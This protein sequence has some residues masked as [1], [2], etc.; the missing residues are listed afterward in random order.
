MSGGLLAT[1]RAG[2][3]ARVADCVLQVPN[4]DTCSGDVFIGGGVV[5]LLICWER[6]SLS[7][8]GA[9]SASKSVPDWYM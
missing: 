3:E 4:D 7:S 2:V 5:C 8:L 6:D 9:E 1:L